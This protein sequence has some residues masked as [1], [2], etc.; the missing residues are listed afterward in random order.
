MS[1]V[2]Y[3]NIGSAEITNNTRIRIQFSDTGCRANRCGQST[4]APSIPTMHPIQT[5]T[6]KTLKGEQTLNSIINPTTASSTVAA[7]DM[8]SVPLRN[9]PP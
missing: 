1:F 3:R 9:T 4:A 6:R 2:R 8:E 5:Q 7:V